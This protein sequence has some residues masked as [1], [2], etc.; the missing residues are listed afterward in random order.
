MRAI[1]N[2]ERL[3]QLAHSFGRGAQS[4]YFLQRS[5]KVTRG[6]FNCLIIL[7][8]FRHAAL[9]SAAYPERGV[10]VRLRPGAPSQIDRSTK[11]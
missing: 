4:E 2:A 6:T 10:P 8:L 3:Y 11:G 1:V 9:K 5:C 7:R